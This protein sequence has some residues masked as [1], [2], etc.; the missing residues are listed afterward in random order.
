MDVI[1]FGWYLQAFATCLAKDFVVSG[2][3]LGI[4]QRSSEL[5]ARI[6]NSAKFILPEE[7]L[8]S[9]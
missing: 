3:A 1:V 8:L 7:P 2:L 9:P 6:A 4:I 5:V